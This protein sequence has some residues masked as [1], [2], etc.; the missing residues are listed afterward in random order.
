LKFQSDSLS[1]LN[2]KRELKYFE[3]F[4][5]FYVC[6]NNTFLTGGMR[7][8]VE[9]LLFIFFFLTTLI[10]SQENYRVTKVKFQGNESISSRTLLGKMSLQPKSGL[11]RLDNQKGV[12]FSEAM[13]ENDINELTHFYQQNGFIHVNISSEVFAINDRRETVKIRMLIQEGRRVHV[14]KINF[15][16]TQSRHSAR[17]DSI[18]QRR[19]KFKLHEGSNFIE[20]VFLKDLAV[21]KNE[22]VNSGFAFA[23]VDYNLVVDAEENTVEIQFK[24]TPGP[25]CRFGDISISG[26]E[27][28][29]YPLIA[30]QLAFEKGDIFSQRKIEKSQEQIYALNVFRIVSLTAQREKVSDAVIPIGITIRE[31]PRFTHKYGVGWGREE[32]FRG[33][34]DFEWL[35]FLG[36][37]RRINL[38]IKHSALEPYNV[39]VRFTQPAFLQPNTSLGL[40][41]FLRRQHEPGYKI[42]RYGSHV[43]LQHQIRSGLTTG[44]TYTFET[45]T[46][47]TTSVAAIDAP[48][49]LTDLYNKSSLTLSLAQNSTDDMFSPTRGFSTGLSFKWSGIGPS[50]YHYLKGVADVRYYR[51]IARVVLASRLK[52][53]HIMSQ[54]ASNFIPV[55]DR[56][57]AGGANSVRG[58]S[59]HDLGS[60]DSR[61]KPAGGHSLVEGSLECRIPVY[62]ALSSALFWDF[63]RVGEDYP[64]LTQKPQQSVGMGLRFST[65]IG[66]IR[67]DIAAPVGKWEQQ[68]RWHLSIGEA[69]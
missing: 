1:F 15:S 45:I 59:R 68:I 21:L 51:A 65:P 38:L 23:N 67:F 58:W 26:T 18:T 66:P 25:L 55:E 35:R 19:A 44:A 27:H 17:I 20:P 62:R 57:F 32:E 22:L 46:L 11:K 50:T 2:N 12:S 60:K 41:P 6:F 34:I 42:G 54:D 43:Y 9:R 52:V 48:E 29:S 30:K 3:I 24:I 36:G 37:A 53:G 28:I 8:F 69:F 10:F 56:F 7:I 39:N 33:M 31:A 63:G 40:N 13:L 5:K 14:S 47:D 16:L 4:A 64:E 49:G 61:G